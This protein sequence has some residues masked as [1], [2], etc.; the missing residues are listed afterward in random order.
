MQI[1]NPQMY[2][3]K[4]KAEYNVEICT[5]ICNMNKKYSNEK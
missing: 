5:H 2:K 1:I 3:S 4:Y